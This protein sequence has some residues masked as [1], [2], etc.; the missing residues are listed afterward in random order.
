[1]KILVTDD[2]FD[3]FVIAVG[4]SVGPCQHEFGV[5]D[6]QAL[7]FHRA[8]VEMVDGDD[9]VQIQ[10][11]FQAVRLFIPAH[12]ILQG[13]HRMGAFVDIVRLDENFQCDLAATAGRETICNAIQLACDQREQITGLGEWIFPTDPMPVTLEFTLTGFIAIRQQHRVARLVGDQGGFKPTHHVRSIQ[14]PGNLA[15]TFRLALSAQHAI[16]QVQAF[17]R[18]IGFWVYAVLQAQCERRVLR[19]LMD[20]QTVDG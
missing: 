13:L 10:I 1:M 4:R 19:Y 17:Q 15:K 11:V 2:A 16:R 7:V 14:E 20:G 6:V 8:H 12:R 18:G 5:E 9:H 3:V